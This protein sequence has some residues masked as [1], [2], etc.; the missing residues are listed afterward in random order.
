MY[1]I[2][3]FGNLRLQIFLPLCEKDK[4]FKNNKIMLHHFLSPYLYREDYHYID[5]QYG[6]LELSSKELIRNEEDNISL[7][8]E[9]RIESAKKIF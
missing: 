8:Y 2:L 3:V 9:S 7:K 4:S 5:A 6:T 1:F